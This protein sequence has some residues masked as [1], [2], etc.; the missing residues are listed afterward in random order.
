MQVFGKEWFD[1]HQV[2][3]VRFANTGLGRA[4]FGIPAVPVIGIS[5]AGFSFVTG[6]NV[7]EGKLLCECRAS[8]NNLYANRL[9][10][11]GASFWWTLHFADWAA[12]DRQR[13]VPGF[14]FASLAKNSAAGENY[15]YDVTFSTSRAEPEGDPFSAHRT[16]A[17]WWYAGVGET[18][19]YTGGI[20]VAYS[21]PG[22]VVRLRRS[23]LNF[24]TSSIGR[25][26]KVSA[27]S[28]YGY[29]FGAAS[30]YAPWSTYNKNDFVFVPWAPAS[31]SV[32]AGADFDNFT[33]S[34][35]GACAWNGVGGY[36]GNAFTGGKSISLSTAAVTP[37]TATSLM[38]MY[39]GDMDGTDPTL[40]GYVSVFYYI[41]SR[42]SASNHPQLTVTYEYPIKV[43]IGDSWK[44]VA[45]IK[46]NIG[47]SWKTLAD[48]KINIGDAWKAVL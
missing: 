29:E 33:A 26:A 3:L 13:M 10:K 11:Y 15:C 12:L 4:V 6:I 7:R 46:V 18:Y 20:V 40:T 16:T 27:V 39:R 34:V 41:H 42:D 47:D 19:L 1:R 31:L 32:S 45:D 23:G 2:K 21:T 35:L 44:D 28:L 37:A 25:A 9:R 30:G 14:G 22:N 43:N 24:D 38:A 5:P 36:W 8:G 17:S 48:L